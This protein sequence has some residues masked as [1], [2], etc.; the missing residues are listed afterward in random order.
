M[1]KNKSKIKKDLNKFNTLNMIIR[2]ERECKR[3][4]NQTKEM[5]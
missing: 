4:L 2:N 3:L 1:K 5:R